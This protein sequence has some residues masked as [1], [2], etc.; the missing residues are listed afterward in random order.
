MGGSQTEV[1]EERKAMSYQVSI[2][3]RALKDIE[4]LPLKTARQISK[5][6]DGLANNPR[7]QGCKKLKG[8]QEYIWRIRAGDYRVLYTIEETIRV[9]DIRRIGHRKDVYK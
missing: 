6:I 8:E 3:S 7:P 5:A 2:R 4:A 9:I 1:E